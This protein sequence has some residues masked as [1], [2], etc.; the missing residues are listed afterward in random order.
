MHRQHLLISLIVGIV[1]GVLMTAATV[2]LAG[3]LDP[4]AGPG[5]PGSQMYTLDQ[6]YHRINSRTIS[7]KMTAFTEPGGGPATGTMHTLNDIYT[8]LGE[9][10]AV[11]RSG[12]FTSYAANDDAAQLKGVAQ[13][14]PRFTVN[15]NGTVTDNLTGLI[16][17]RLANC[18][19]FFDSD[20]T[21]D[22]L[23]NW[24]AA[25][26]AVSSLE[27]GHC[28]LT[29]GSVAGNWRLPNLRELHSLLNY[30]YT[31]P[32]L[33]NAAGTGH[34]VPDDPF[35]GA[36]TDYYWTSTTRADPIDWAYYVNL[37]DGRILDGDK[38][39]ETHYVWAVRGG[40]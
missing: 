13:P 28:G 22:N 32:S 6:I 17:L 36:Q 7:S 26:A 11:A 33:S 31:A 24:P 19:S 30:A 39:T 3:G 16:W 1:I 27:S 23:R 38:A 10:A 20:P 15:G 37:Y 8:L 25:L 34:F 35:Y 21:G 40:E 29:D 9:R 2:A 4:S 18:S 5:D 12:Q 14:N